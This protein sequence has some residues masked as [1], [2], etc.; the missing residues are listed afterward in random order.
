MSPSIARLLK[1]IKG[2]AGLRTRCVQR[3]IW[4]QLLVVDSW[5]NEVVQVAKTILPLEQ[6][7]FIVKQYYE[8]CSLKQVRSDFV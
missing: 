5:A 8:T 3:F 4:F 1:Y 6:R 2:N 7:A